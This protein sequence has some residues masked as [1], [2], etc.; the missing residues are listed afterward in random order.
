MV[1]C[2]M[3]ICVEKL[4]KSQAMQFVISQATHAWD[5]IYK[6]LYE[7]KLLENGPL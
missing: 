6:T 1:V 3:F 5:A 2:N 7:S 4:W